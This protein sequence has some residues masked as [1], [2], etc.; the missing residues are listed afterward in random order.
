MAVLVALVM[1]AGVF[2]APDVVSA[3][4]SDPGS[5]ESG[6]KSVPVS[7]ISPLK[8][9]PVKMPQW[10]PPVAAWPAGG[11]G[12]VPVDASVAGA[13]KVAPSAAAKATGAAPGGLPVV[14]R[15][16]ADA[17]GSAEA[18]RPGVR[19]GGDAPASLRVRVLDRDTAKAAGVD[20]AL[21]TVERA[22]G[23]ADSGAVALD[24]DYSGFA[25][26][27]G[28]D[29]ALRL[30]LVEYPAC[31]LITPGVTECSQHR[32]VAG[33]VNVTSAR[34]VSVDRLPVSGD[35]QESPQAAGDLRVLAVM[36]A[37]SGPGG[38]YGQTSMAPSSSWAIGEQGADFS[39]SYPLNVPPSVGGPTPDLKL[40]YSSG[41]V[42]GRSTRENSQAS[43]A[44]MGWS[45]DVGY[46]EREYRS[47]ADDGLSYQDL[48]YYSDNA[49]MVFGGRSVR[50]IKDG[51][52]VW[53][54]QSDDGL[55]IERLWV[56]GNNT[57]S[58]EHWRVTDLDGV[59]Y[60]F[61]RG[62]NMGSDRLDESKWTW[63]A[64][65]VPVYSN[66]PWEPCYRSTSLYDN[67]CYEAYRWN[68][69]YVVDPRGN[70][71]TYFYEPYKGSYGG[72]LGSH[73]EAKYA[74]TT[75]LKRVEYGT[76]SGQEWSTPAPM[77]VSFA[78]SARCPADQLCYQH[79]ENWPDTPWDLYCAETL[80][81]NQC[82]HYSPSFW[83]PLKLESA[84]SEVWDTAT[85]A[86]TPVDQ[87]DFTYSYPS[88]GDHVLPAGDD[89]TASLWL[90]TITR[91]GQA[92]GPGVS[93][94]PVVAPVVSFGGQKTNNRVAWGNNAGGAPPLMHWRINQIYN[95]IGGRTDV[96]YKTPNCS[97]TAANPAYPSTEDNV[98]A[99]W[100]QHYN[101][102][103]VWF[104]KNLVD[105]VVEWDL[106]GGGPAETWR[107]DY[108]GWGSNVA[109]LWA[110]DTNDTTPAARRSW[111]QWRGYPVV[112]TS[113]GP[114]GGPYQTTRALFFRG[115]NGDIGPGG[116]S[117]PASIT[118]S[119]GTITD[120]DFMGGTVRERTVLDGGEI[121][122]STIIDQTFTSLGGVF[123]NAVW[124]YRPG[125][126]RTRTNVGP[127][128]WRW[129]R[130]EQGYDQYGQLNKVKDF[131]DEAVTGDETCT[132][133]E[134]AYNT[135][136]HL[137]NFP[138]EVYT[139][140]GPQCAGTE[141]LLSETRAFFDGSTT[142][143]A[144]PTKGLVTKTETLVST[145][146]NVWATT[147]AGYDIQGRPTSS[148]DARGQTST[149]TY[150]PATGGPVLQ[151]TTT[152]S[153]NHSIVTTAHPGRGL[154]VT[155]TDP[156]GKTTT[157]RHDSLGRR[158]ATWQPGTP[159]SGV[160]DVEHVY[161]PSSTAANVV[162]TKRV[163][164]NGNQIV[165]YELY[166]GRG[167]LRQTQQP[168]AR[169]TGGRIIADTK[170]DSYGQTAVTSSLYNASEPAGTLVAFTDVSVLTQSRYT[171]DLLG[172]VKTD[173]FWSA[174]VKQ[175]QT[176]T[177]YGGDRTMV[178]PPTGGIPTTT[179][180]D[181]LGQTRELRQHLGPDTT[182]PYQATTYTYD[183]LGRMTE[184]KDPAN[185]AWTTSY[186]LGGRVRQ[187]VDPDKGTTT[188]TYNAAGD[189][190]TTKDARQVTLAYGYDTVGRRTSLWQDAVGTGTK[191][192]EWVY[193][194][195]A[196]GGTAKGQLTTS[197]RW[198]D[199]A[200]YRQEITGFDDAYRPLGTTT[201]LPASMGTLA[202]PWTASTTYK[203]D[204]SVATK[205]YPAAGSLPAETVTFGYDN[206]GY[207]LTATG[208]DTYV[209]DTTY[210]S[211]GQVHLRTL[212]AGTK[213]V[214]LETYWDPPTGRLRIN[215]VSTENQ[216][217]PGTFVPQLTE[218]YNYDQAG[219]VIGI[220]ENAGADETFVSRQCFTYDHLRQLTEA[221]TTTAGACQTTPTQAA[222]GG[223]DPYWTSYR[224]NTIG[225]RTQ[226]TI[227]TPGGN[228]TRTYT[229]PTSGTN[230]VRPHAVQNVAITGP[231]TGTDTYGYDQT[232]NTTTRNL[233]GKLG[234]TLT[235]DPEGHLATVTDANGET[236]Y[237]YTA[238][239]VR[240]LGF[241]PGS[242]TTLYLG[243]YE[244][245][246]TTTGVTCTR[247]Y[248]VATRTTTGGLTWLGTDH[249]NTGQVSID[250]ATLAMTR[251][252][253][254]P[255]GNPRGALPAWPTTRG[256]LDGTADN[257]GL[258]H[259]GA[260]EYEPN[261]GRFV[262]VDP[263]MNLADPTQWNGY[264][265][266]NSN[267]VTNSD[268]SGLICL[269]ECGSPI[270][271]EFQKSRKKGGSS[272]GGGRSGGSIALADKHWDDRKK[273]EKEGFA[274]TF[275]NDSIYCSN[276]AYK[277]CK[278]VRELVA[279]DKMTPVEAAL[280][281]LC[282][283]HEGCIK[284]L[285]GN[286]A[287]LE[288]L[289]LAL[290]AIGFIPV[291]GEW[292]D[293]ADVVLSLA[294]GDM[295][296]AGWSALAIIPFLG[297]FAGAKRASDLT[298]KIEACNSFIP[299][300]L[301]QL[302]DGTT[303]PIEDLV[304]GD[305]VL[306][307][308]PQT[309]TTAPKEVAA[310]IVGTGDKVLVD[311]TVDTDGP[312]GDATAIITATGGHPFWVPATKT[313][314][315]AVD[316]QAEEWLQ[317]ASGAPAKVIGTHTRNLTATVHNLTVAD[318]HT[319]YVLAGNTSI[320]VHNDAC[321]V[322]S[323]YRGGRDGDVSFAPRPSDYKVD[324]AT[325]FVKETY[326]VSVFDNPGSIASRGFEPHAIDDLS[327]P[328]TLQ[329]IRR[330][331][332]PGH[333]EIVPAPGA[334][335]T[336]ARYA[337]ELS[338]VRCICGGGR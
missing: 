337:E 48:C 210:N 276:Y 233:A 192:A 166:D 50:L 10:Q 257:T 43:W 253:T 91:T 11:T 262:S 207:P 93:G 162:T 67:R 117:R 245:R 86:Y 84:H 5:P 77:R 114:N 62:Y 215:R 301:V 174:D 70:S 312:A 189:V 74:L 133:T 55:R 87:Y 29:Y 211:R 85:G 229:Y 6:V 106:T 51:N 15:A 57:T 294:Q 324:P 131:G 226:E 318:I 171:Y 264:A 44:G 241:E 115:M 103:W 266:A 89:T 200:A 278:K 234:Q 52:E 292:A 255:F 270:D 129:T 175:W 88:N 30:G 38:D 109:A 198:H 206:A 90:N 27:V 76:R 28:G 188:M 326:G 261:A 53:R 243:D 19:V 205:T 271:D 128:T 199:N 250:P 204:G 78:T 49:T 203:P 107:Y 240:L 338:K 108:A 8:S 12:V 179:I 221:W 309:G 214:R 66:N 329:I 137:I 181:A 313:W 232:G 269:E 295:S 178:T 277:N 195:L 286:A 132:G 216:T 268:P 239:G 24:V 151:T 224:H 56:G 196:T 315:K 146:P 94:A 314:T 209:S 194:T 125:T 140:G 248:G 32:P 213:R 82:G 119:Q 159:T 142:L 26:M 332:T 170:Y 155:V 145:G 212:G 45:F 143:H 33:A 136:D 138:S 65:W 92:S 75:T 218:T 116:I 252:R 280:E 173:E 58:G 41:S 71:M 100:P 256:F 290:T 327:L 304:V 46:I 336:P 9:D 333:Y 265:Y 112:E 61:G 83:T 303:K 191:R 263:V 127:N 225:N 134:Y 139:R 165:S 64:Q 14:A 316:L 152:N 25:G 1:V 242:V 282:N 176:A 231:S 40:N 228:T 2:A 185:N 208:L 230:A 260:R 37:T 69:D 150:V 172:R 126:T 130:T 60:Y 111:T 308:D 259:L 124:R 193:D 197:I 4:P 320:L 289:Q 167:R 158:V 331:K 81:A 104:H 183:R 291:V 105:S 220:R 334:N 244:L 293:A 118:D 238:D 235:W 95:G 7:P 18:L 202:G 168:A 187:T 307:T 300:T 154:P 274:E 31:V 13:A 219:N 156:N 36:A 190:L 330:G 227:H 254:D 34:V 79:P 22:D 323:Y 325:G 296:G 164:P 298:K 102:N 59:Q 180:V 335:L 96:W 222:V 97:A 63:S 247:H 68:L 80:P 141:P 98:M 275:T 236:S 113:H 121:R 249:H 39:Y 223:P 23:R 305:I 99:C 35:T 72:M 17:A 149:T 317:T 73:G 285:T 311:I 123:P 273:A 319:Y 42:D 267:P 237:L 302:A 157:M 310:S 153:L 47:C 16:A 144:A 283:G 20:G 297:A 110:Y 288:G 101:G 299:G 279:A 148:K 328:S 272:S 281:I 163:G 160:A 161:A 201:R 182:S 184:M 217:N 21:F 169:A 287:G 186:D 322:A 135:T 258:T 122:S 284:E 306:A 251:R 54:A 321:G 120:Y 147:E 177:S 246:R 3:A